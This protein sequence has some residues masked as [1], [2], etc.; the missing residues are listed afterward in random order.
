MAKGA[1]GN[2]VY[3]VGEHVR[4]TGAGVGIVS[5]AFLF[6]AIIDPL[7][8]KL[9]DKAEPFG[10]LMFDCSLYG[11]GAMLVGSLIMY[12]ASPRKP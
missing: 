3:H 6:L 8:G 1:E 9:G 4:V 5:S 11:L 2:W 10:D 12:L 7:V